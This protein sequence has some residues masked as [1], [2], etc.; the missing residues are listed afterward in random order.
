[1][2]ELE[3]TRGSFSSDQE[4]VRQG[5]WDG[6]VRSILERQQRLQISVVERER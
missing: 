4:R 6:S 3:V 2:L 5:P 1:M